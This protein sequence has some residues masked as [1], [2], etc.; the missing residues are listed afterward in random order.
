MILLALLRR[1]SPFTRCLAPRC[2]LVAVFLLASAV[3]A[4]PELYLCLRRTIPTLADA[5]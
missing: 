2:V 1:A 4:G 3:F 5:S